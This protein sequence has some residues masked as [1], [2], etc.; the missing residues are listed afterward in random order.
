M[1]WCMA[2]LSPISVHK[3]GGTSVGS[4]ERMRSVVDVI[5]SQN[6]GTQPVV[7]VSAMAGV[8]DRLVEVIERGLACQPIDSILEALEESHQAIADRLQLSQAAR[9]SL[10]TALDT[11]HRR[12]FRRLVQI[13]GRTT[14]HEHLR[15]DILACGE[16]LSVQLVAAAFLERS[17]DSEPLDASTFLETDQNHGDAS[18]R[19]QQ[20]IQS[21]RAALIPVLERCAIPVV[22]GFCGRSPLGHPTTM[23][24]GGSDLT[25]TILGAS[26]EANA[27]HLWSDVAGVFTADPRIVPDALPISHLNYGEA[28][29][30]SFFGA[31]VLHP[32]TMAPVSEQG[33]PVRCRST[34]EPETPGTWID[35]Q[36]AIGRGPVKASSI[37]GEQRVITVQGRGMPGAP[38]V[39]AAVFTTLAE[40]GVSVRMICQ[41]SSEISISIVIA[42][43]DAQR[44]H[45]ALASLAL[46]EA[47]HG[48]EDVFLG[49][50]VS[51]VAIVGNGMRSTRGIAARFCGALSESDINII[52]MTHQM[53]ISVAVDA[54]RAV[55]AIRA[56]HAEFGLDRFETGATDAHL[57]LVLLGV[58][59]S[60][61]G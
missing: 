4:L 13:A 11:V 3:F 60:G 38:G 45:R 33:I 12:L 22:T 49:G 44:A 17:T 47:A 59:R 41:A 43:N 37:I 9:S 21:V 6:D 57:D 2:A 61:D 29:E 28:A 31:K 36:A 46:E 58:A 25:A 18:P 14:E 8:T 20:T 19:G 42:E 23:G 50:P 48:I 1:F 53:S 35:G 56:V 40:H 30:L 32:R 26:L 51:I 5:L 54:E 34:L 27:V 24:R 7:V 15:D 39:A 55:D 16:R 10:T 52:A